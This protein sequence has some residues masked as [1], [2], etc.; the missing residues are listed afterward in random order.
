MLTIQSP[1][2]RGDLAAYPLKKGVRAGRH[3]WRGLGLYGEW[4]V[5]INQHKVAGSLLKP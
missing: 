2:A 5:F 1:G 4:P 3:Q